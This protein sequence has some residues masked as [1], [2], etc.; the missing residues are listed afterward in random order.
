MQLHFLIF[1]ENSEGL[2][3]FCLPANTVRGSVFGFINRPP[4]PSRQ[5]QFSLKVLY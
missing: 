2:V 1:S 4:G 5:V 3:D